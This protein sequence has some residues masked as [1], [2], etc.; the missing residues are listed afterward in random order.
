MSNVEKI[1]LEVSRLSQQELARFRAWYSGFDA[2]AWD[3]QLE[4]DAASGKLDRL[5]A[6]ALQAHSAGKTKAL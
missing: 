2:D 3:R 4:Q 1:E 5:A 6:K